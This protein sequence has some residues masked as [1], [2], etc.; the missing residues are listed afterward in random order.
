MRELEEVLNERDVAHGPPP[1]VL[2]HRGAPRLAPEN[3]LSSLR[4]ALEL[5]LDG[6]EYDLQGSRDGDPVLLHDVTLGRTT[7]GHGSVEVASLTELA[8]LDAGAWFGK[9]FTGEPV[10]LL[11]EA[12]ELDGLGIPGRDAA[13]AA[14]HMIELKRPDLVARVGAALAS[15]ARP[16]PV[17]IASFHRAVCLEATDQGLPAMLLGVRATEEDRRFVRD[18]RLAAYGVAAFGW[19][20]EVAQAEWP[21]ERWAW[22]VNR[23][24]ELLEA[25]RRP[26]FGFN[27]D[28]PLRALSVRALVAATPEDQGEYPL[29]VPELEMLPGTLS[30]AGAGESRASGEWTGDWSFPVHVR[31]PFAHRVDVE[32]GFRARRGA[33][34]ISGGPSEFSL[35]PGEHRE[36]RLRLVGGSFSPGLEPLLQARFAPAPTGSG[37]A[38]VLDAPIERVRRV[39]ARDVAVRLEALRES[40]GQ[41]PASFVLR[42]QG[43]HLLCEIED[44]GGLAEAQIFVHLDGETFPGSRGIRLHLPRDFDLRPE[45]L[46]FT[47]ALTGFDPEGDPRRVVIRRWAGGF[48]GGGLA[49]SPGRLLPRPPG[50]ER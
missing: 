1:I 20:T 33:F 7:D 46:R 13:E 28:E 41:R 8:Q 9:A 22:T 32:L 24:D 17:R 40:P 44:D 42:R 34:D 19:R 12:L 4:R 50:S 48:P 3:T 36:T 29:Q 14:L 16:L 10:P 26:L 35:E 45:G 43:V 31:N 38:L 23:P 37:S 6:V 39:I 27:T 11:D 21:C 18:H 47:V 2:G 5:G 25:C 49:G 30:N 15:L